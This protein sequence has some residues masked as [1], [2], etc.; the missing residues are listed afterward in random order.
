MWCC[1]FLTVLVSCECLSKVDINN[2][3]EEG[4]GE[5]FYGDVMR[6]KWWGIAE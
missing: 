5:V 4:C 2:C 3:C 6:R 1:F